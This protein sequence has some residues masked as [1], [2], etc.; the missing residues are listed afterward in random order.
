MKITYRL[1]LMSWLALAACSTTTPDGTPPE[2]TAALSCPVERCTG[3]A[4]DRFTP[5]GDIVDGSG[6]DKLGAPGTV[7]PD[8][9][10]ITRRVVLTDRGRYVAPVVPA[11]RSSA[12][13]RIAIVDGVIRPV[14]LELLRSGA[15]SQQAPDLAA[16]IFGDGKSVVDD[17]GDTA[18]GGLL[19]TPARTNPAPC[20]ENPDEDCY[21][22]VIVRRNDDAGALV[23]APL[24]V[25]VSSPKTLQAAVVGLQVGTQTSVALPFHSS[26]EMVPTA[27]G[28]L[29]T[30]RIHDGDDHGKAASITYRLSGG[31][32]VAQPV[33]LA[34]A[35]AKDACDIT[36]WLAQDSAKVL[37]SIRP[38]PAAFYDPRLHDAHG[39]P[40]TGSRRGR[41]ATSM[42]T[43]SPR[44]PSSQGRIRGSTARAITSCS[45][46]SIRAR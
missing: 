12:D 23:S 13:G 8:V 20:P 32:V 11:W 3:T 7:T 31:R 27:D 22:L 6:I 33:S 10:L 36:E 2:T 26:G 28:H 18:T 14:K 40:I 29:V 38:W 30:L 41:S 19:C 21:D 34:Y 4:C 35:Y 24:H 42:A 37:T 46:P 39:A 25:R 9:P 15:I 16:S 44:T 1:Q 45:R 5:A 43:S 17:F